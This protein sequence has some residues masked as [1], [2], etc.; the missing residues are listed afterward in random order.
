MKKLVP[1]FILLMIAM[2]F[3]GCQKTDLNTLLTRTMTF[4]NKDF[5]IELPNRFQYATHESY[6]YLYQDLPHSLMFMASIQTLNE[7]L[8]TQNYVEQDYLKKLLEEADLQ[9]VNLTEHDNGLSYLEF[10]SLV[11]GKTYQF[12][13]FLSLQ[14][15]TLWAFQFSCFKKDYPACKDAFLKYA[16][17][18]QFKN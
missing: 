7:E 14:N 3:T 16:S 4:E 9:R 8:L 11:G 13:M 18:I 2:A 15:E 10:E 1:Y 5:S 6:E 12:V 17:S